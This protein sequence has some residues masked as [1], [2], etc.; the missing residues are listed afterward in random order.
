[1][2]SRPESLA[3]KAI[4]SFAELPALVSS[5]LAMHSLSTVSFPTEHSS[6]LQ[7]K[8]ESRYQNDEVVDDI[9]DSGIQSFK[10]RVCRHLVSSL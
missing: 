9:H 6:M 4:M 2:P 8:S 10:S 1:M 7:F 3:T 5:C